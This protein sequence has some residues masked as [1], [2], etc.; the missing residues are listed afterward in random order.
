MKKISEQAIDRIANN[1][2]PYAQ[3]GDMIVFR[4]NEAVYYN[5]SHC[6][7]DRTSLTN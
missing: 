6:E 5:E 3:E 4:K 7:L 1:W 2:L